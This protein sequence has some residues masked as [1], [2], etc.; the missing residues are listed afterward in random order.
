M[1]RMLASRR[2]FLASTAALAAFGARAQDAFPSAPIR[3]VVPFAAGGATDVLGRDL[4]KAMGTQ[5]GQSFVIDNLGGGAGVP[6]LN[7]VARARAD[8]Y[9]LLFAASGNITAQPLLEKN[10]VDI[11]SQLTPVGMIATAPHVLVVT[12]K[13]PFRSLADLIAYAKAHPGEL[14]FGSAGVGGLAHLGT[15]LFARAAQVDIRHVPYRGAS[16]ALTDLVSGQ[17]HGMFGT[18]PSFTGMVQSGAIR[19]IGLTAASAATPLRGIPLIS[20]TVPGFGYKSWNGLFAPAGTPAPVIAR[21]YAAMKQASADKGVATR[22]DEQGVDIALADS[23]ELADIVRRERSV[24]DK[25]IRD[26]RIQL[27]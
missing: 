10:R 26:A 22:F 19:A 23:A 14:N 8:G 7:T 5:L 24:W 11:L 13:M 9:T 1:T 17:I 12:S 2:T 20:G 18:M 3:M 25:V 27:H 16:Q 6:A 21:I 15:E 4:A